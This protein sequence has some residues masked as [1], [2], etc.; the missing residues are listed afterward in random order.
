MAFPRSDVEKKTT[1]I[2]GSFL[3]EVAHAIVFDVVAKPHSQD[4]ARKEPVSPLVPDRAQRQGAEYMRHGTLSRHAAIETKSARALDKAA[5]RHTPAEFVERL[6][7]FMIK[8][9]WSRGST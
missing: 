6:T 1:D 3:S 2:I 9:R 5:Q 4:M 7:N 8:H